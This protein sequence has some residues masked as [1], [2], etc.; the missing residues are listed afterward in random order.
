MENKAFLGFLAVCSIAFV[1]LLKPFFAAIF[2]AL[3]LAIIFF[4][5]KKWL[6]AK[7]G[8][9][10]NLASGI[11][12]FASVCIVITPLII[13]TGIAIDQSSDILQKIKS[14]ELRPEDYVDK[15]QE[16]IPHAEKL[17][18]RFGLSIESIES[19]VRDGIREVA[20]TMAKNSFL[21]GQSTLNF[22]L[23]FGVMLYLAFFLL[24]DGDY[25]ARILFKALPFGDRREKLLF[26]K[27]A[28]VTRA[29][30]KGNLVVAI[31]Q[32]A[33]GGIAFA[34][35]GITGAA[36]WA[37]IMAIAS[38]VPVVGS[39]IVWGPVVIYLLALGDTTKALVLLFV[40]ALVIG[41]VDNILRPMLVGR[42]TKMPDYVVLLSTLSG[43]AMLGLSGFAIGP[44][45]AALFFASWAIFI[46]DFLDSDEAHKNSNESD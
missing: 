17:L 31:V 1:W 30:V 2:W 45:I 22:V 8:D 43:I 14:G 25:I 26:Q 13:I 10:P 40:G 3:A 15:V 23:N 21:I 19:T 36:L 37:L 20:K 9:K 27:F 32:G 5:L 18:N 42:D 38:M 39:G 11:T 46:R 6:L 44:L 29:T 35:L 7:I 33:I 41:T 24:R 4:P 12:L 16:Q 34:L 28:E